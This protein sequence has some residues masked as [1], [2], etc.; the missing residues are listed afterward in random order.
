[1]PII[2][3]PCLHAVVVPSRKKRSYAISLSDGRFEIHRVPAG[4][5]TLKVWHPRIGSF[6]IDVMVPQEGTL[7]VD[8]EL[9]VK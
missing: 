6:D 1:M 2:A 3:R 5:L 7:R 8:V 4:E 9:P